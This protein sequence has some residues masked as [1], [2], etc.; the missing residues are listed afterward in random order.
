MSDLKDAKKRMKKA[1]KSLAK[2][3]VNYF[4]SGKYGSDKQIALCKTRL[5]NAR[6]RADIAKEKLE[7]AKKANPNFVIKTVDYIK[8]SPVKKAFSW[9]GLVVTTIVT[10]IAGVVIYDYFSDDEENLETIAD[11]V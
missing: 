3:E 5:Q 8:D 2:A 1:K 6:K 7:A 4:K 11:V 10:T 9:T